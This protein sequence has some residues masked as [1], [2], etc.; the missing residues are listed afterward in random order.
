MVKLLIKR[1]ISIREG[2]LGY[3]ARL[4]IILKEYDFYKLIYGTK[5]NA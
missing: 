2:S 3:K 5:I 4:R 1:L